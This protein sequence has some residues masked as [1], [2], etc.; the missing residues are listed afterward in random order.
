LLHGGDG[1]GYEQVDLDALVARE[2]PITMGADVGGFV[3]LEPDTFW[4]IT[5]T[6]FGP[7]LSSHLTFRTDVEILSH[8]HTTFANEHVD[9]LVF[10]RDQDLIFYPDPCTPGPSNPICD[11]GVHVYHARTAER[12][13]AEAIDTGFSPI[14]VVLSR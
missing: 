14:E 4:L 1:G 11:I 8:P 13:S 12:A 6:E 10:D 7:G 3:V 9:D 5:H 2:L